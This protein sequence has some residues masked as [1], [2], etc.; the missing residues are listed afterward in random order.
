MR[1]VETISARLPANLKT[2]EETMNKIGTKLNLYAVY[3]AYVSGVLYEAFVNRGEMFFAR[4]RTW[5][6]DFPTKTRSSDSRSTA[7]QSEA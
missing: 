5:S 3:Y 4:T 6:H 2:K 1:V 7:P